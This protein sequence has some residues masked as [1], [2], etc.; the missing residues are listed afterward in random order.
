MVLSMLLV[1]AA[2]FAVTFLVLPRG[3]KYL[4]SIGL[5]VKDMGKKHQPLVPISGGTIVMIGLFIALL[6]YIFI[7]TFILKDEASNAIILASICAMVIIAFIGFMDD[8]SIR[9]TKKGLYVGLKRWQKPLLT[10][11]AA[12]PLMVIK[13]GFS[14]MTVPF[15]GSVDFGLLYP[16]LLVPIGVVGAANM[17]NLLEGFNGMGAGMGIVYTLSLGLYAYVNGRTDAAV[18]AFAVL[19]TLVAFFIFNK[20]PAKV[21]PGDSLTYL[22]GAAIVSIAVVGNIEKAALIV[23]IPFIVE[24]FLK[25][26]SR[27]KAQTY[28]K[29]TDDGKIK[30]IY[31]RIYSIPHFFT[32]S[33]RFTEKQVVAFMILIQMVFSGL[34]WFI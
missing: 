28:G 23:S 25:L 14:T 31:E 13:A 33:G 5:D 24:F 8:L 29:V 27:F 32:R 15:I 17:V 30:S 34:I 16:L 10:L 19:G 12:I 20:V 18:I 4:S 21:L 1:L 11:P 6:F 22:L 3:I 26:R 7:K 2:G 9:E